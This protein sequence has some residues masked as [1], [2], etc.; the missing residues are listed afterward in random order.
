MTKTTFSEL[1][2]QPQVLQAI[3]ELGFVEATAVQAQSIPVIRTGVDVLAQSQTGTGKTMAFAIPAVESID[4][5]NKHV[6]VLVLSPTRELSQQCGQ[7]IRKIAKHLSYIKTADIFGGADYV[8][9][10]R[11]LKD[12]NLVIGT[13]GRIM[14]HMKRNSLDLSHLKMIVLDE[15]DEMLNMGFKEDIETILQDVPESRQIVLFSATIPSGILAITK[16]FQRDPVHITT[17]AA[18]TMLENIE[19]RV[20]DVPMHQKPQ[21][22][23]LLMHYCKPTRAIV[24]ANTKAMVDELTELLGST[25]FYTQGLHGDMKQLQRTSVMNGFKTGKVQVL[26]AT[27]VAA[28]GIDV[29]GVDYVFN[30]DIPKVSE[31]YVHRIGRTGRAGRSGT[32]ITLCSGRQQLLQLQRLS[33]QIKSTI[34]PMDLPTI[35]QIQERNAERD[36]ED[37]RLQLNETIPD[38]HLK[39]MATLVEEGHN[40][41]HIAAALVGMAFQHK[42]HGL[43]DVKMPKRVKLN[44]DRKE[45]SFEDRKPRLSKDGKEGKVEK[46]GFKP[47]CGELVLSIGRASRV[48]PNHIV[49][50]ITEASGISSKEIGQIDISD[51]C[52]VV[53][54]P[55]EALDHVLHS[56]RGVKICGKPVT[57][58]ALVEPKRKRLEKKP[59]HKKKDAKPFKKKFKD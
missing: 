53:K 32:A 20:V 30:F 37:L 43:E 48:K 35:A 59:F 4:P 26:V 12:A 25:G 9:Q 28:R 38:A 49:G 57:A 16:Q 45:K 50:A 47:Y 10:F 21:A 19:Q 44:L 41:S 3:E 51:D 1:D 58:T 14:D 39:M 56:M 29:S 2:L 36:L 24:F 13:P 11:A 31:Y 52:S 40:P 6:Q 23:K 34:L 33:N 42:L 18:A 46:H 55:M 8:T 27:D 15:A 7:E 17:Q 22:M 5:E 54:I